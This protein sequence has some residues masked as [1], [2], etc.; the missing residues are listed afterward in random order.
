MKAKN[1]FGPILPPGSA[2]GRIA[3]KHRSHV[4][5]MVFIGVAV[6]VFSLALLLIGGCIHAR[7]IDDAVVTGKHQ[8]VFAAAT[9]KPS[10]PARLPA[11]V[12]N[13]SPMRAPMEAARSSPPSAAASVTPKSAP[14]IATQAITARNYSVVKGDTLSKIAKANGVSVSA[15][16][17]AN[18]GVAPAKLKVGQVLHIPPGGQKP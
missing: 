15:L 18:P 6:G 10:V 11:M 5:V 8:V 17:K 9:N 13:N 3:A 12:T 7:H 4:R 16:T 1:P 14:L 2:L